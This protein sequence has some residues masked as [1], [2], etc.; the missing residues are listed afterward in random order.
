[1]NKLSSDSYLHPLPGQVIGI[2]LPVRFTYPFHY[3]P[4]PLVRL[5]AEE[6]LHYLSARND[7]QEELQQGK[8]FGVLIVQQA[9]RSCGYLAAFSGNLAG[10]NLHPFFVPPVYDLLQPDGF[11]RIEEANISAINRQIRELESS[12]EYQSCEA[13]F[14]MPGTAPDRNWNVPGKN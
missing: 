9:D 1:M 13:A 2:P 7:W 8:M 3:T 6:V 10:S 12:P 5:A 4:H 14:G 11:F